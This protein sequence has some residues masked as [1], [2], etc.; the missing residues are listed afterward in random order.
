MKFLNILWVILLLSCHKESCGDRDTKSSSS[1]S[2][3]EKMIAEGSY[4]NYMTA[5]YFADGGSVI[6]GF[7]NHNGE[8]LYVFFDYSI[9]SGKDHRRVFVQRSYNDPDAVEV[10]PRSDLES[11]VVT[12]IKEARLHSALEPLLPERSLAIKILQTRD[13]EL[14]LMREVRSVPSETPDVEEP[15]PSLE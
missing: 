5:D 7:I 12:L 14:R 4:W 15:Q 3:P 9:G 13:V 1:A 10:V 2:W 8:I 11:N 6:M